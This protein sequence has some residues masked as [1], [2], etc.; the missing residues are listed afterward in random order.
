MKVIKLTERDLQNIVKT[1]LKEQFEDR[2]DE[3]QS[4]K[5][6]IEQVQR[7]LKQI[8]PNLNLGTTGPNKDGV[9]GVYGELTRQAV[10]KFQKENGIKQT[11]NVG[12]VTAA[13]LGVQPLVGKAIT[14]TA[15]SPSTTGKV[16][17]A[18][19]SGAV[20]A[21]SE[22]AEWKTDSNLSQQVKNQIA[23]LERNKI[24]GNEKF[25]ILDDANSVVHTFLP[26]YKRQKSYY[27]LTGQGA[28][29][30]KLLTN[31]FYSKL[32]Q[33]AGEDVKSLFNGNFDGFFKH[34]SKSIDGGY[35]TGD[36]E[37]VRDTPSGI[38]RRASGILD[39]IE[40]RIAQS[41]D[42]Y[43]YGPKYI[44]W[45][46]LD[47]RELWTAWHGTNL[48]DRVPVLNA[49]DV[50]NQTPGTRKMSKGCVNFK[51]SDIE[52]IDDFVS[53]HQK[54]IWLPSDTSKIVDVPKRSTFEKILRAPKDAWDYI[55]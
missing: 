3:V 45:Q 31:Q 42:E 39:V 30:D 5:Y 44:S 24:M 37:K 51:N 23:Y 34:M 48:K 9:D 29:G 14:S 49:K 53:Y 35:K 1:V 2:R 18:V 46:T 50:K 33:A 7:K 25:T 15:V 28:Q 32:W 26:G 17:G 38:F 6:K 16:G 8:Y 54:S 55:F 40:D 20:A 13:K 36:F 12:P 22:A 41:A 47:N 10:I 11:G 19:G 43:V 52:E 21:G 4:P 27:V